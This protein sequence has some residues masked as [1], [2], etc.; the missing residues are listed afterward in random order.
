MATR[1]PG[2]FLSPLHLGS[3]TALSAAVSAA[4]DPSPLPEGYSERWQRLV[5]GWVWRPSPDATATPLRG[6]DADDG[7]VEL[8]PGEWWFAEARSFESSS[9]GLE[10]FTP[11]P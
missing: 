5:D 6:K 11:S 2:R 4:A 3:L 10:S 9:S 1:R 8:A 7:I